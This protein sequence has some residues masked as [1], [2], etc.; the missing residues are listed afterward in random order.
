MALNPLAQTVVLA[1]ITSHRDVCLC[2]LCTMPCLD[3]ES[4]LQ[5]FNEEK[6]LPATLELLGQLTPQP[7]EVIV[8]DG[9]SQDRQGMIPAPMPFCI[10]DVRC[11]AAS[12]AKH[13]QGH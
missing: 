11:H 10:A 8:V 4:S 1:S 13:R 7:H 6:G 9:S 3:K 12:S 2:L 5:A